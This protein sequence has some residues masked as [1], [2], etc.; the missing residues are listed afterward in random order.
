M[1]VPA[2]QI[3]PAFIV[4]ARRAPGMAFSRSASSKMMSGDLPPS[5]SVQGMIR[6]AAACATARPPRTL[7]VKAI[8][9]T[10]WFRTSASPVAAAPSTT[11]STPAGR[12]HLST[13]IRARWIN[14]AEVCSDGFAATVL[15]TA[16]AGA[17]PRAA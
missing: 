10:A 3:C 1:R 14:E 2:V 5:S 16:I 15:P 9:R 8:L 11:F 7:P 17:M 13:A 6:S 12:P 4:K